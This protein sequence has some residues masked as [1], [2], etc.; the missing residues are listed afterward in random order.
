MDS[1]KKLTIIRHTS[2]AI[3]KGLIYGRT[4]VPLSDTFQ[5]EA[6]IIRNKLNSDFD[7]IYTS[8]SKR[9]VEL[10]NLLWPKFP[11]TEDERIMELNFGTWEGKNW[12]DIDQTSEANYWFNDFIN[13]PCPKGES[14]ADLLN[15]VES[16][17]HSI[18][19]SPYKNIAIVCHGGSIRAFL[20]IINQRSP[21]EVFD[22]KINF[23][24]VISLEISKS[25][26]YEQ[27]AAK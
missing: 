20:S 6:K 24:E 16:F 7:K 22:Q 12:N 1:I 11:K 10:S 23:G 5:F 27:F 2:V 19:Q 15:R 4:D 9:C 17:I 18:Q 14:Y 25:K 26:T 13:Q 8:P 21:K 3:E